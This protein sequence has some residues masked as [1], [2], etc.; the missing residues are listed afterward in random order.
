MIQKVLLNSVSILIVTSAIM[1]AVFILRYAYLPPQIPLFYSLQSGN[2]QVVDLPYIFVL[3]LA[4]ICTV[5]INSL[6]SRTLLKNIEIITHITRMTNIFLS[7]IC[8]YVFVKIIL[9][10]TF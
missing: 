6:I 4:L 1:I 9:L 3:P 8:T 7:L 2:E 10:V 5:A